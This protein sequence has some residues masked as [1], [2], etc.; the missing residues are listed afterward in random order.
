[1]VKG[2]EVYRSLRKTYRSLKREFKAITESHGLTWTQFHAL[3]HINVEGVPFNFLSEHLHCHAS[4]LTGL[5]DRMIEKGIVTRE[6]SQED[7]RVWLIK[8]TEKGQEFKNM[9]LPI[10]RDNIEK[11]FSVLEQEELDTLY[12]LL[13]KLR[14]GS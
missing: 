9:L 3:Y 13:E 7:R 1:M 8:L 4:N 5:I 6:Q 14:S 12:S 2:R 11:R 10:Y